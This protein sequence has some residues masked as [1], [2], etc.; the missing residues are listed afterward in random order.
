ML[1]CLKR[2]CFRVRARRKLTREETRERD[3]LMPY[4]PSQL[5]MVWTV[6]LSILTA[7]SL[8]AC[9]DAN[10]V[11]GPPAP[12]TP[13]P[14]TVLTSSPLPA[15]ATGVPYNITLAPGG[16][17]P[18]YTWNLVP[19]SPAL[20]NGLTLNPS[21]GNIIGVPTA[22]GTT[23]N[24]FKLQDSKGESVQKPFSI[25]VTITPGPVTVLTP[26]LPSGVLNQSYTG[27]A[28]SA[29]GGRSP[30]TWDII[31]GALPAGLN[32]D[33]SGVIR[34]TPVGGTS[35]ATFRVRD[36]GNPQDTATKPLSITITQPTPP[37]ITTTSLPAGTV[38][39]AYNQTVLAAGGTGTRAWSVSSGDL[40]PGLNLNSSN[41][42]IS[43]VP[44]QTGSFSFT[45][46]VTDQT[47]LSDDQ[48]LSITIN[49]PAPPS[50]ETTSLPNGTVGTAYSQTLQTTGGLGTLTWGITAGAL[51]LG[52][53][54]DGTGLTSGTPVIAGRPSDFTVQV[55]DQ[56]QRSATQ[57]LSIEIFNGP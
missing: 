14:L 23:P 8:N 33:P 46:R 16:G 10:N 9:G 20:P 43:G 19:G 50:I 22:T 48:N 54:L 34:G 17:T 40:P 44:A 35:S 41:G 53:E 26:S 1:V 31:G 56:A 2:L 29:T 36:S 52:L 51:P 39:T 55:I 47:P 4:H 42:N 5:N 12:A 7:L 37:R 45:L 28:L 13:G 49:L 6:L 27:A 30:Y 38:N 57:N 32:L 11:S 18:P 25:T 15:G 24:V 21:S 3:C